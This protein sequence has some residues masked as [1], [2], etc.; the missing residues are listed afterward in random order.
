MLP[1]LSEKSYWRLFLAFGV[2]VSLFIG[3]S[4]YQEISP[5]KFIDNVFYD[6]FIANTGAKAK[7]DSIVVVD[8]DDISLDVA[9]QWPWPR[10]R[11]ANLIEIIAAGNPASIGIDIIFAEPDRSALS[12]IKKAFQDEFGLELGFTGIPPGLTDNDGFLGHVLSQTPSVGAT[13]FYFDH[14]SKDKGCTGNG[15][16]LSITEQ[17]LLSLPQAEGVLCNTPSI[18]EAI[19]SIGFVNNQADNDGLLRK[20]PLLIEY[21]NNIYPNLSL[22]SYMLAMNVSEISLTQGSLG[23]T[24]NIGTK[25]IAIDRQGY[26]FLKFNGPGR[27]HNFVSAIDVLR[28]KIDPKSFAEKIVLIGSTAAGTNDIHHTPVDVQFPGVETHAVIIDNIINNDF[29]YRPSWFR[30]A[31]LFS[32]M[33]VGILTTLMFLNANISLIV[34][35]SF[36]LCLTVFILSYTLFTLNG[37][38]LSPGAPILNILSLFSLLSTTRYALEK[39]RAF[40]WYKQLANVQQ[41]SLES[42]ANVAET[43]DPETGAHIKRTQHYARVLASCLKLQNKFPG[44]ITNEYIETIFISAPLHDIGKVGV[45]DRILLKPGK[46][47]DAEFAIMKNHTTY[48]SRIIKTTAKKIRGDNFLSMAGDIAISHH[49]KW[50]GSGYPNGLSGNDIPLSGRILAVA[51]VYDALISARCYKAPFTHKKSMSIINEGNGSHFDPEVVS[52]FQASVHEIQEIATRFQDD[53]SEASES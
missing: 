15:L 34:G 33:I 50:D 41:V 17:N 30:G 28:G 13:Y 35:G 10:Y 20:L 37:V 19:H 14:T 27:Q 42:M 31:T 22:A 12:V 1:L 32:V 5:V 45:P 52:A 51:D 23:T 21:Q 9:G 11:V 39:K 7:N 24:L 18:N 48:G 36:T 53:E 38:F 6:F 3:I 43:R 4:G 49:E 26:A 29:I 8:I 44:I 40:R 2:S 46:L 25:S 47:D 16:S